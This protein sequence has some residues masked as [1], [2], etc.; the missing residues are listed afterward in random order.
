MCR[1]T[2][3]WPVLYSIWC[4]GDNM[5]DFSWILLYLT[6]KRRMEKNEKIH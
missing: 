2:V 5:W 6:T 4:V 3:I 1:E